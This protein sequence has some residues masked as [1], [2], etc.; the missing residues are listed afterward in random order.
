MFT[1]LDRITYKRQKIPFLQ[2]LG[3]DKK[4]PMFSEN[5]VGS[6][7]RI[8]STPTSIFYSSNVHN[9]RAKEPN[10]LRGHSTA[11]KINYRQSLRTQQLSLKLVHKP[12]IHCSKNGWLSQTSDQFE[13]TKPFHKISTLQNGMGTNAQR[14]VATRRFSH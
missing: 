12:L 4:R 11:A 3:K 9:K 8:Y 7:A 13:T 6:Q 10:R 5:S 14:Y 1:K 2:K